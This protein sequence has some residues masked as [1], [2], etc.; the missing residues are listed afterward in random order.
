MGIDIRHKHP[1]KGRRTAP[2][3]EDPY[4]RLLVKLYR[5]LARR[6]DAPFNKVLGHSARSKQPVAGAHTFVCRLC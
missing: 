4:L 5:F 6:T 2:K 3:S 1:K